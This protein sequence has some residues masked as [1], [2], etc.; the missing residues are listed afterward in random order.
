[1]GM[2]EA[3]SPYLVVLG[4]AQD[5]GYPH[6]GCSRPCCAPA[7][8]DPAARRFVSCL[9]LVD[10][11]SGGRWMFDATPDF[12]DQLQLL[13]R[14]APASGGA[15][16]PGLDGIFLT[17][18]HIGHYT[19]LMQLGREV[20]GARQVTVF[21]MPRM[22]AFLTANGPWSQLVALDNIRLRTLEPDEPVRLPCNV[23][24]TPFLVPHRNEFAETVG[25]SLRGPR[26][27]AL[28]IPD[29]DKWDRWERDVGELVR[30]H[31]RC[32]LD[33][34]FHAA[35]EVPGRDMSRIPHP[36]FAESRERFAPLDPLERARIRFIH[37][38]HTNPMLRPESPAARDV[39]AA[40]FGIA[41][42]GERF[43]L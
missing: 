6:A 9:A 24:V 7:W 11:L 5:G 35:G 13:E 36:F 20:I 39:R 8:S 40:G 42:Q 43:A 27:A 4:I 16:P 10:P 22:R 3:A 15:A 2:T 21:A 37:L 17:H 28:F 29:I 1:M 32:F 34:T 23:E 25:F 19:G 18:A 41:E 14:L 31:D 26:H 12:R 33:A 38:N 30:T